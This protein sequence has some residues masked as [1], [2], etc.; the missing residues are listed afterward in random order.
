MLDTLISIATGIACV[1]AFGVGLM[2]SALIAVE[3]RKEFIPQ[4][5]S[6]VPCLSF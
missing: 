4:I 1:S 3:L 5:V 6:F 2:V